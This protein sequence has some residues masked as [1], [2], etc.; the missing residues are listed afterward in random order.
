[1]RNNPESSKADLHTHTTA[2]DGSHS[3]SDNVRMAKEAGL[4][5]I[6]ITDHDTIAGVGEAIEAGKRYGIVVVPGIELSTV[7]NG[8]DIHVLG[9]GYRIDDADWLR[10]LELQREARNRRNA[11]ILE[12]LAKLGMPVSA[13]ELAVAAAAGAAGSGSGRRKDG[14][15]GRPH[16]ATAMADK[17]YV[18]DVREAFDRWIGEGKPAYASEQRISPLEAIDWIHAAGGT[19]IVAHPGIYGDDE[20]VLSLLESGADGLEAYHSDHGE[21]EERKYAGW[22][23]ARGKLVTGGSDFHGVKNGVAFHG[24]IGSRTTNMAVVARLLGEA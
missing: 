16:I 13:E 15:V 23:V 8:R 12:A 9:Y 3:P 14:S 11:A 10:R 17:G 7:A 1:M 19:A 22:A 2:S 6:A 4:A 20:L 24:A 21:E 5:A 18:A